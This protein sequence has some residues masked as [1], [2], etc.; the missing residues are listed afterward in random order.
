MKQALCN[1]IAALEERLEDLNDN[2]F[3]SLYIK[4]GLQRDIGVL[5]DFVRDFE[6]RAVTIIRD[7]ENGPVTYIGS[8]PQRAPNR[9]NP[10][11]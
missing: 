4:A 9:L 1:A 11:T 5:N 3:E 2:S 10:T 6:K 7:E 8:W